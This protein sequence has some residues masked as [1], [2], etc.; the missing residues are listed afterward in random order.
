M[1]KA[2]TL[3]LALVMTAGSAGAGEV[4]C[5][6][7]GQFYGPGAV[8]CQAGSQVQCV[9]GRWNPLGLACADEGAGTGGMREQ[10]GVP[11]AGDGAVPPAPRDAPP[12][13][14]AHP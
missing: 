8:S 4:R 2:G 11:Q 7:G 1:R 14:P 9:D 12:V 13:Q 3:L 5:M 6:Y 10:P